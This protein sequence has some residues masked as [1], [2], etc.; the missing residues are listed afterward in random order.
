[1]RTTSYNLE[2]VAASLARHGAW[3]HIKMRARQVYLV[4]R[5]KLPRLI[6]QRQHT[7]SFYMSADRNTL[8]TTVMPAT[9]CCIREVVKARLFRQASLNPP[10]GS[11]QLAC[12]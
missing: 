8:S 9:V 12:V 1:M 3:I 11:S 4:T 5:R 2:R 10:F 7:A 6:H